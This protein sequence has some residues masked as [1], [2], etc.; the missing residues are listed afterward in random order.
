MKD[1]PKTS[2]EL[3]ALGDFTFWKEA[4]QAENDSI[5]SNHTSELVDLPQGSKLI[6][7][8]WVFRRKYY[9][10]DTLNTYHARLVTNGF[11]QKK[12]IDYFNTYGPVARLTTMRVL[13]VLASLHNF[14]VHQMD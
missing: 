9:S 5:I 4:M 13:F 11:Q 8:K 1:D 10:D 2:K 12:G 14:F 7:G 6:R 3:M